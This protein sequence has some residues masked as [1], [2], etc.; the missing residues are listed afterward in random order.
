ML[1]RLLFIVAVLLLPSLAS[2]REAFHGWC[3][4]GNQSVVTQGLSSTTKVQKSNASCVVTVFLHG[5][6]LATIYADNNGTPL[7]NPFQAQT[8]GLVIWYAD[9]GRYDI[10]FSPGTTYLDWLLC[11][12]FVP[13]AV[14]AAG[15]AASA[16]NLLSTTHLD[17][18]P[19]SPP[20]RGDLLAP[21]RYGGT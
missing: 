15:G 20:V 10:Q 5:A 19:F 16:H 13:G 18:I 9:D 6:G 11:D 8:N 4:L 1:R 21:M 12:P 7:A 3:E 17:T 14:C 2:A